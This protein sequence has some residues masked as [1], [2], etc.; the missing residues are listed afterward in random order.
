MLESEGEALHT[1]EHT[2]KYVTEL[3]T[4][5]AAGEIQRI[6]IQEDDYTLNLK[7]NWDNVAVG[8]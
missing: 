5:K 6:C 3:I 1:G 7:I 4:E 2:I 8:F